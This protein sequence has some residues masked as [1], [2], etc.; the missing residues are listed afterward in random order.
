ME[1]NAKFLSVNCQTN[2]LNYGFNIINRKYKKV[3]YFSLDEREL[4]LYA[5]Q[6]ELKYEKSLKDLTKELSA[7]KGFLTCG[8]KFSLLFS[9]NKNSIK[10]CC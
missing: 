1:K 5:S 2:S 8:G 7:K 9:E 4:Q 6:K 10:I 3:D